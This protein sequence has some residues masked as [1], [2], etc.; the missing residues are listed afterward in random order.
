MQPFIVSLVA[1]CFFPLVPLLAE[2]GLTSSIQPET[3][4]LNAIVY[5]AA[6]A[7]VSR[8]QAITMAG[9]FF[10]LVCALIYTAVLYHD[11]AHAN[12][13]FVK[14]GSVICEVLIAVFLIC[15]VIER[16]ARHYVEREPFLEF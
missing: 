15:Y 12:M 3:W 1:G 13:P 10:S 9:L 5:L 16:F 11:P 14:Y 8:N 7:I 4:A 2:A 6:V